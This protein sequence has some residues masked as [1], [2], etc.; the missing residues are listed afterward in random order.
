MA[1]EVLMR[2]QESKEIAPK[3][4]SPSI[5]PATAA[6]MELLQGLKPDRDFLAKLTRVTARSVQQNRFYW[7]LL[8]KVIENQEFYRRSEQLHFWLKVKLGYV[9]AVEFH[10]GQMVTRVKSTSFENMDTDDFKQYLDAVI[11]LVCEEII[12]NMERR[13]LVHEVE[14]MLGMS[15]GSLWQGRVAA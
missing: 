4:W 8:G 14:S 7:S 1:L 9:D 11:A 10:N 3:V 6:D 5:V 13:A 12:P 2:T 15:Y